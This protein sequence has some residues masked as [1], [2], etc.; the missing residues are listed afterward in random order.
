MLMS[1]PKLVALRLYNITLGRFE[2]C[3]RL[4]RKALVWRYVKTKAPGSRYSPTSK[5][6]DM[7][8][9]GGDWRGR[10]APRRSGSGAGEGR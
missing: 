9:L 7:S 2:I 8:E 5:F 3:T 6:F 10:A 1:T 4:L